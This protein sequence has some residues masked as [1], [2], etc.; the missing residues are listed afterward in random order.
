MLSDMTTMLGARTLAASTLKFASRLKKLLTIAVA[1]PKER[2]PAS[3]ARSAKTG[4]KAME[5]RE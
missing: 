5:R 4:A 3:H 2:Q 1:T